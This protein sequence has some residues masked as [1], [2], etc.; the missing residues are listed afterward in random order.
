MF[1]FTVVEVVVLVVVEV[2]VV[3]VGEGVVVVVDV[4]KFNIYIHNEC[5]Y[6]GNTG[7]PCLWFQLELMI[8]V[9]WL[10]VRSDITNI[11]WDKFVK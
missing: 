9:K 7:C 10:D 3:V 11:F 4:Y 5:R 1:M 8:Q 2:V 6:S